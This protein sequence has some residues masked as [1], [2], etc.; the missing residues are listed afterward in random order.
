MIE[1]EYQKTEGEQMASYQ[2]LMVE[3]NDGESASY[4]VNFATA[5]FEK[6][7]LFYWLKSFSGTYRFHCGDKHVTLDTGVEVRPI[8]V[9]SWSVSP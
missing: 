1:W 8:T 9:K 5:G 3:W 7:G 2:K 4:Y 6:M